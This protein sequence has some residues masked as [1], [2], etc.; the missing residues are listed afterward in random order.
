M[1][2]N[3]WDPVAQAYQ[4]YGSVGFPEILP[5]MA[6]W[7]KPQASYPAE[8]ISVTNPPTAYSPLDYGKLYR[9]LKPSGDRYDQDANC[10]ISLTTGWNMIGSPYLASTVLATATVTY[11]GQ[12]KTFAQASSGSDNE[13]W[14]EGYAW[15][16][17][18]A[19]GAINPASGYKLV[20]P[21]QSGALRTIDPWR[22]YWIKAHRDCTLT[23]SAP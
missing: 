17:D 10:P 15:M 21:A 6:M 16:W 8:E 20:H 1:R 11:Q 5:G 23:L 9:L 18:A 19:A 13:K 2:I 12:T 22:G 14:I 7:I 3:I 4:T